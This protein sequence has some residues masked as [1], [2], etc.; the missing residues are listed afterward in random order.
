MP[1]EEVNRRLTDLV[2]LTSDVVW[3]A[4]RKFRIRSISAIVVKVTG[5]LA[6]DLTGKVLTDIWRPQN[7]N[8]LSA[9]KPFRDV[10]CS[11]T[12]HDGELRYFLLS[13]LPVF[14]SEGQ[15]LYVRGLAKDIT[16]SVLAEIALAD[17]QRYLEKTIEERTSQLRE[18][19][20][21]KS[22]FLAEMSHE[23]RTPLNAIIG[24]SQALRAGIGGVLSDRQTEYVGDIQTSGELLLSLI[25]D[26]LD[27]SKIEAGRF[28]LSEENIN[29]NNMI[30]TVV[31]Q[32]DHHSTMK[33][34]IVGSAV[35]PN[36]ELYADSR[37]CLQMLSNLLS[38][39]IKFTPEGGRVDINLGHSEN[40]DIE[41]SVSDTSI[42][43]SPSEIETALDK[44][45]QINNSLS[46][47][48]KGTGLGLPLVTSQIKLHGGS[49][50]IQS[51]PDV[52]TTMAL[53][54]PAER[55][56]DSGQ[57]SLF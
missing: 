22:A 44:F 3:E 41:L 13:G 9:M 21:A 24:F 11:L 46:R 47:Q 33:N 57:H 43:M 35:N 40:G 37:L 20:R 7:I 26:L 5:F 45:G 17:H 54:F 49:L 2:R 52:G 14:G 29:I 23:L 30:E 32:L 1:V 48:E 36:V 34:I 19:D 12:T 10:Q 31:H 18:S 55:L 39:A 8:E 56:V 4:D 6:H 42:G 50:R 51:V 38:N 15:F 25:N 53:V 28:D 16:R 27:L